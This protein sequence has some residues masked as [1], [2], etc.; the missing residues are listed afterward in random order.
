MARFTYE[1]LDKNQAM[2]IVV[3]HQEGLYMLTRDRDAVRYKNDVFAHAELGKIFSLPTVITSSSDTGKRV[4]P[5]SHT[6]LIVF[7]KAPM[8]AYPPRFLLCTRTRPSSGA[9]AR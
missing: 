1:R 4:R 9:M 8:D 5:T 3:D 7:S 2:L 6:P